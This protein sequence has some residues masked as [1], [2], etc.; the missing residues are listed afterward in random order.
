LGSVFL[1]NRSSDL[2]SLQKPLKSLYFKYLET[3]LTGSAEDEVKLGTLEITQSGLKVRQ[4]YF[5]T[6]IQFTTLLG[7]KKNKVFFN[8]QAYSKTLTTGTLPDIK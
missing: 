2:F 5:T 4:A 3:K 6:I 7:M 1:S 8:H